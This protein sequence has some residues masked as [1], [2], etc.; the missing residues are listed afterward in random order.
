MT[1]RLELADGIVEDILDW[2]NNE[3]IKYSGMSKPQFVKDAENY[4]I[5]YLIEWDTEENDKPITISKDNI[6]QQDDIVKNKF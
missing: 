4:N 6:R 3:D 1:T 2:W 5:Q